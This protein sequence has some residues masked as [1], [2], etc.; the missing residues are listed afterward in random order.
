MGGTALV[1]RG[2]LVHNI[3]KRGVDEEGLGRWC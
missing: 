2:K 3:G 1:S